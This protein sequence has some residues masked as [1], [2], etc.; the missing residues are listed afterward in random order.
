MFLGL[1]NAL[2]FLLATVLG[3]QATTTTPRSLKFHLRHAH[4]AVLSADDDSFD[5]AAARPRV[6][7]SDYSPSS[8]FVSDDYAISTTTVV[9]HKPPSFDAFSQARHRSMR[10]QQSESLTWKDVEVDGPDVTKRENLLMLAMMTSNAYFERGN[11]E[12]Y[13]VGGYNDSLPYGWEPEADGLRGH[14][15]VSED[16]STVVVT[17]KGTS[18][19]WL[20]GGGGPTVRRDKINDN[21][22]FSCCCAKVGPTWSPVCDCHSGGHKCDQQCVEEALTEETLFYPIGTVCVVTMCCVHLINSSQN[23]YNNV[24]YMYP[25]ANIWIIGHSLGGSLSSLLGAT[26]G[27]PVVTFEAPGE[28]RAAQRLHLPSPP[29]LHHITHVYH[30]ADPIPMGICNGV[31]SACAI[32]GYALESRCHLGKAIR[33]DTIT[34]LGWGANVQ[35]HGILQIIEKL[36]KEDWDPENGIAVP[37][38]AEEVDCVDCFDWEFGSFKNVSKH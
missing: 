8:A 38:A 21:M 14:I 20:V 1:P 29:S 24:T 13:E 26:F 33:Y 9:A 22:L 12:W 19:S 16:E 5:T 17:V 2:Q 15:F 25:D 23:L 6:I 11:K 18:A 36:L 27:V 10:F 28:R 37:V 34:K 35:Y 31:T 7:F 30:T 32:G 3:R 4:A